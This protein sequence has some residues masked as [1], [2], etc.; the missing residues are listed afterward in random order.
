M[1]LSAEFQRSYLEKD[2]YPRNYMLNSIKTYPSALKE[3][4]DRL[5]SVAGDLFQTNLENVEVS[6]RDLKPNN[7]TSTSMC[8]PSKF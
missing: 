1:A 6:F 2:R 5:D 4:S 8:I 3:C 7:G